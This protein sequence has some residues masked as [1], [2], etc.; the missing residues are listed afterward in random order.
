MLTQYENVAIFLISSLRKTPLRHFM[1]QVSIQTSFSAAHSLRNYQGECENLHGHNWKVEVTVASKTL[2]EAG[3]TIDFKI[4]KQKTNAIIQ[5]FDH[6]HLNEIPYFATHNPSSEN[7]AAYLFNQL[8]ESLQGS[9][10]E[11]VQVS[12]GESETS[13]ASYLP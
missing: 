12:V 3:L 4:L 8:K 6:H 7:I 1:Y 13:K 10:V 9:P 5:Q 2:D 11:L